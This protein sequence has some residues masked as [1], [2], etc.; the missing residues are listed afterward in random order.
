MNITRNIPYENF[1]PLENSLEFKMPIVKAYSYRS[2]LFHEKMIENIMRAN[3]NKIAYNYN[4]DEKENKKLN[5]KGDE[6]GLVKSLEMRMNC[7]FLL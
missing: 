5:I 3:L 4:L 2:K 6:E 7:K 1:L